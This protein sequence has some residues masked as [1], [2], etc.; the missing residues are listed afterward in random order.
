[1][2]KY[3]ISIPVFMG[4]SASAALAGSS[5]QAGEARSDAP[6]PATAVV[7]VASGQRDYLEDV[8]QPVSVIGTEEL[9]S[10]QGADFTRVVE[11]LPGVSWSRNGGVGSFTGIRVRGGEAEQLLVLVD[12]VPLA[13]VSSP[14][15]GYD[16]GGLVAGELAQVELLRGPDSLIW[17]SEALAGVIAITTQDAPGM[18]AS[19]EYGAYDTLDLNAQAG[20]SG[21]VL[22]GSLEAGSYRTGGY[23]AAASGTEPDGFR[24]WRLGGKLRAELGGGFTLRGTARYA[25]ARLDIDG[26][27]P[28]DYLFADTGEFQKS[29]QGSG[30]VSLAYSGTAL[31]LAAGFSLA[32][33][34]RDSYD[35]SL[36]DGP[37]YGYRGHRETA[38]LRGKWRISGPLLL[39]FG[40]EQEWRRFSSTFDASKHSASSGAYAQLGYEGGRLKLHGGLR[41]DDHDGF[42]SAVSLG[43]DAAFDLAAG[44]RLRASYGEGFKAPTLFQLYSDYG[45]AALRPERSRALDIGIE[46][47]D[48]NAPLHLALSAFRRDSRDLI[49]FVSCYGVTDGICADRPYGTYDNIGQARA[50]GFELEA[51]V[52]PAESLRLQGVYSYVEAVNRSVGRGQ[53]GPRSRPPSA[54]DDSPCRPTGPRRLAGWRWAPICARFAQL[55]TMQPMLCRWRAMRWAHCAPAIG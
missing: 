47:G 20:F 14:G 10:L 26:F 13:D 2:Y 5:N 33:N 16:F 22:S 52:R 29:R 39:R 7:V 8:A 18:R 9:R 46:R 12:G 45:N 43:A 31:D 23:S 55:S 48:R 24:Q 3:L 51:G 34:Q 11:R 53:S 4:A 50:Q 44:W 41:V 21:E 30:R 19:A 27:P 17:G 6:V 28:P 15:G 35:P 49:D 42:G 32:E 36:S 40:G 38:D 25:A 1:M 54:P 37:A